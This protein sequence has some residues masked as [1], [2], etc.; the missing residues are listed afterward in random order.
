M[1]MSRYMSQAF[2]AQTIS[3]LSP[4]R[5]YISMTYMERDSYPTS[6]ELKEQMEYYDI[7]FDV[8]EKSS[9]NNEVT[10]ILKEGGRVKA[11]INADRGQVKI[12]VE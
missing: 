3:K 1:M 4:L 10:Y 12:E 11:T 2:K 7:Y 6:A 9:A 5:L 8:E